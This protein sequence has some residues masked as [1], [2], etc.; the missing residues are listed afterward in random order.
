MSAALQNYESGGEIYLGSKLLA[1]ITK[2]QISHDGGLSDVDTTIKGYAGTA[3]GPLKVSITLSSA[4]PKAG[5]EYD[6]YEALRSRAVLTFRR[7]AGGQSRSYQVRAGNL[8]ESFD[9]SNAAEAT[10]MLRGKA[11][12]ATT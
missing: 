4:M 10:V 1:E 3:S 12:G 6:Y 11:I 2:Y 7:R 9:V 5:L 8:D